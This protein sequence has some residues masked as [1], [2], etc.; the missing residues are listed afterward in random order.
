MPDETPGGDAIMW[1][2]YH[3]VQIFPA[4]IVSINWLIVFD[5]KEYIPH[6]SVFQSK[7]RT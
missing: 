1:V 2:S 4:A 5:Q 6:I 3:F 7:V